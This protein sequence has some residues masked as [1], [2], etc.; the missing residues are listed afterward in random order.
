M[1]ETIHYLWQLLPELT[2]AARFVTA[3]ITLGL[4]TS[5]GIRRLRRESRPRLTGE[6]PIALG[7]HNKE[8]ITRTGTP[9]N[10]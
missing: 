1:H 9:S 10:R 7:N 6:A 8:K 4:T 2:V 3:L 5:T